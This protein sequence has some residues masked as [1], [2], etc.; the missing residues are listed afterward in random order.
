MNK[1]H[2]VLR[3]LKNKFVHQIQSYKWAEFLSSKVINSHK[4]ER[5]RDKLRNIFCQSWLRRQVLIFDI[6]KYKLFLSNA[7]GHSTSEGT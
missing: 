1:G 4:N 5:M 3:S 7:C 6:R 2:K